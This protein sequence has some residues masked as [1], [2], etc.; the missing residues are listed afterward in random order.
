MMVNHKGDLP[1]FIMQLREDYEDE[2]IRGTMRPK[3]LKYNK[4]VAEH[5][6]LKRKRKAKDFF[7]VIDCLGLVAR[8]HKKSLMSYGDDFEGR[9]LTVIYHYQEDEE[10]ETVT[11]YPLPGYRKPPAKLGIE[12]VMRSKFNKMSLIN[13]K[14]DTPT[15]VNRATELG[16]EELIA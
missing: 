13:L 7:E 11:R 3:P 10:G 2:S 8:R 16:K 12:W 9:G 15:N 4:S 1:D 6:C 5:L 14:D